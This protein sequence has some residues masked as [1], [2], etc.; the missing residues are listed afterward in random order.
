MKVDELIKTSNMFAVRARMEEMLR[1]LLE[2]PELVVG[3]SH[4]Y[5]GFNIFDNAPLS[6]TRLHTAIVRILCQGH[7]GADIYM[8]VSGWDSRRW[9]MNCVQE[10]DVDALIRRIA[11]EIQ[12][13]AS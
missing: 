10:V 6:G 11:W 4:P 7:M 3:V 2:M 9:L 12:K 8:K 13:D 1:E 5:R